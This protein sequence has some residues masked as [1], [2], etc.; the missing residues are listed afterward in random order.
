MVRQRTRK[1]RFI[2]T[3]VLTLAGTDFGLYLKVKSQQSSMFLVVQNRWP[4]V[5]VLGAC[6]VAVALCSSIANAQTLH[7]QD[8]PNHYVVLIDRSGSTVGTAARQESYLKALHQMLSSLL[9]EGGRLNKLTS[10]EEASR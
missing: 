3:L 9:F 10:S 4:F 6:I 1:L 5:F 2:L 7:L 8:H